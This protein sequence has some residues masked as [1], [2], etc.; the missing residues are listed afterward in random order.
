MVTSEIEQSSARIA[1]LRHEIAA[2]AAVHTDGTQATLSSGKRT[3]VARC[4]LMALACVMCLPV[5][6]VDA[7]DDADSDTSAAMRPLSV[8]LPAP[9]ISD[10]ESAAYALLHEHTGAFS[11]NNE[12]AVEYRIKDIGAVGGIMSTIRSGSEVAPGALPDIAL[13]P[14]R[15][16][17]PTQARQ[18][19]QSMETL[20]SSWLI[21]DLGDTLA[22]GQIPL[23]GNVALYGLPYFL[24]V[25]HSV[26][27]GALARAGDSPSFEDVLANNARMLFPAARPSGLNQTFY[28]QYLA[29]GGSSARDGSLDIDE[30]ALSAVLEFYERLLL[31]GG[32]ST[33]VLSY[34]SPSEYLDSF[35]QG[36]GEAQIGVFW[37]SEFLAIRDQH[38]PGAAPGTIPA[39]NGGSRATQ[40]GW[41]W[42]IVTPDVTRQTLSARFLEWM[43]EPEFHAAFSKSLYQL[44][45][46]S[47]ILR[48]SLPEDI[49]DEFFSDLLARAI[50]PLPESEGGTV[51]RIMQEALIKVLR[52]ETSAAAATRQVVNQFAGR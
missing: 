38:L 33:D 20:F 26:A 8:W 50:A 51:P 23:E 35:I 36:A 47:S 9:L 2:I 29:A 6:L 1:E 45:A 41:L 32:L 34:Q 39:P 48:E 12:I 24:D 43:T 30:A 10:D 13:I 31:Q 7:Q 49:D 14:R 28:L 42:V 15:E 19:L 5:A 44:P 16:F 21:N 46:Q 25:L 22:F 11:D 40:A 37:S 52:G 27:T 17:S 18:Y 3:A 4:L